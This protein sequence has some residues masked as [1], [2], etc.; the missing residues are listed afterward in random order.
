MVKKQKYA[1][2][3]QDLNKAY[4]LANK[5]VQEYKMGKDSAELIEKL[6]NELR[7]NLSNKDTEIRRLKEIMIKN[8]VITVDDI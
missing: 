2:N 6:S 4:E 1:I 3:S 7:T 5:I 8:E